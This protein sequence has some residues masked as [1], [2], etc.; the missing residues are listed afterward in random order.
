M[1]RPR[2][3]IPGPIEV[4]PEVLDPMDDPLEPHYGPEW[5]A[6]Y[7]EV[8]EALRRVFRTEGDI[9]LLVGSGSAGLDA[10]I[11]SSVG[12]GGRILVLRNGFFGTRLA[13]IAH[14]YTANVAVLDFPWG[15]PVYPKKTGD[16]LKHHPQDVVAV[17]HCET[18]TGVLNPVE[19]LGRVCSRH[20]ALL[21]VDA[22]SSLGIEPL[23]MDRWSIGLCVAASQKGLECPPGLSPVAVAPEAWEFIAQRETPGWYLN[24]R[25]WRRYWEEWGDWHPH[26]VTHVVN[27]VKALRRALRR[28]SAEGLEARLRRHR[29]VA[30]RLRRGLRELGL[31]PM[32]R[33][34]FAS[35]GVTAASAPRGKTE[36]FLAILRERHGYLLA[37]SLGEWRGKVFRIGHMGPAATPETI[38]G[39]LEAIRHTLEDLRA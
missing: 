10:A 9:F 34:E 4:A 20:G 8:T 6:L 7:R 38:D 26:P 14:S 12:N 33:D 21:L 37:G 31:N 32:V 15:E 1:R 22:I 3:M 25:V 35:H 5:T 16:F 13:E 29:E 24:L 23:E 18:S 36:E 39:L 28:I 30:A 17:V 27:V 19:E 11:G 2:L